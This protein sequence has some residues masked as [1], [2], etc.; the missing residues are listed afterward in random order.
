MHLFSILR[1]GATQ[2]Y[3]NNR[4]CSFHKSVCSIVAVVFFCTTMYAQRPGEGCAPPHY[5]ARTDRKVEPYPKS[6]LPLGGAGTIVVDPNFGSRILRVTDEKAGPVG[7]GGAFKTPSSA[8]QNSWNKD[9]TAFYVVAAGGQN[10]LYHFDP[11]EMRARQGE[12]LKLNWKGEPQFSYTD[13]NV[14]YGINGEEN[15]FQQYDISTHR[16]R[17]VEKFSDCLKLSAGDSGRD[18]TVSA[19][20]TRLSAS[21]G[22]GQ[23]EYRF[24][25][26]YDRKQ[27]CRWYNTQTGEV[28]GQWGPKGTISIPDRAVLHNSRMSKS[29]KFVYMTRGS[30]PGIGKNYLVWEV[31]TTNVQVCPKQCHAHHALG[32]SHIIGPSG[33]SHPLDL[34]SVPLNHLD[35]S[36]HL[37]PGLEPIRGVEFWYD[38]HLSWNNTNA[39]DSAPVCLSTYNTK[40][41][42]IPGAPLN[43]AGPWENE[44]LCVSTDGKG[45]VWRFAH[46]YSTAQNGFWSSPRGNISQDG[47]FF[48]FTSDWQDQLGE[49]PR[50]GK[51]DKYRTDVF[52]VELK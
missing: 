25:Y 51:K 6:P 36:S 41:P 21:L 7:K 26:I 2:E 38:K 3:G 32:Y 34:T 40:N 11:N 50:P 39:D 46:T 27:G 35:Q 29:G 37:V 18:I 19:D 42:D 43:T 4:P 17:T 12:P 48:A 28:G 20:D 9:S 8:E 52:V 49:E 13:P 1:E 15:S 31:D 45:T 33:Q 10:V 5:C 24:I 44:I 47:R 22:S 16:V 30:G 23:D 14:L